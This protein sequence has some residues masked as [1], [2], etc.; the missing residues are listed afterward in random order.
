MDQVGRDYSGSLSN[1]PVQAESSLSTLRRIVPR[2]LLNIF[3]EDL[4]IKF[5]VHAFMICFFSTAALFC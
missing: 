5:N 1:L 3:G 4:P 2:Q